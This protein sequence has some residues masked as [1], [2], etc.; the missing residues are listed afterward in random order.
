MVLATRQGLVTMQHQSVH[1]RRTHAD[2]HAFLHVRGNTS[3]VA[4]PCAGALQLPCQ[5]QHRFPHSKLQQLLSAC[6]LVVTAGATW[7]RPE[8]CSINFSSVHVRALYIVH[9][10]SCAQQGAYMPDILQ[11]PT[12]Q[13]KPSMRVLTRAFRTNASFIPSSLHVLLLPVL[14]STAHEAYLGTPPPHRPSSCGSK[15]RPTP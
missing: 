11:D 6:M 3:C 8:S 2:Q 9:C 10:T 15:E 14:L 5:P 13:R 1:P 4:G 12:L 7:S